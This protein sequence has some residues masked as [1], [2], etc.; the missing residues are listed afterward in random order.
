L[1]TGEEGIN[2][3]DGGRE[4]NSTKIARIPIF[5]IGVILFVWRF[6]SL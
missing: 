3:T 1:L 4:N 6:S 5:V 2:R